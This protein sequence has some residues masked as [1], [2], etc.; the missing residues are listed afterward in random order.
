MTD[1]ANMTEDIEAP[2]DWGPLSDL[3][4]NPFM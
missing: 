1:Q 2:A 3:P 4:G